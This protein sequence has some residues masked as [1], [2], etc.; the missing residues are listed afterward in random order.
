MGRPVK[1]SNDVH[2]IRERASRS[3]TETWSRGDIE[4]LFGI[5]PSSA[6]S[7]MKSIGSVEVVGGTHFVDRGSLLSF[8]DEM[9]AADS[10]EAGMQARLLEADA[11]PRPKALRVA[12]PADLRN[13]M[14]RDLPDNIRLSPGRLEIT[15]DTA[16]A[17]LE[18]LVALATIMENDLDRFQMAVE[19]P[20]TAEIDCGL[21]DLLGRMRSNTTNS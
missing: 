20:R 6:Q 17:M 16:I 5:R 15:A 14:L 1:W 4:H 12:L 18:S 11:P 2:A 10:V 19:P 7:L 8:L 13:V 9:I 21:T 3:R